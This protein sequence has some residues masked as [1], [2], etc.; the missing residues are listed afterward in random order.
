[1]MVVEINTNMEHWWNDY[2]RG[3]E[4]N[5]KKNLSRCQIYAIDAA[6]KGLG[7]NSDPI[8]ERPASKWSMT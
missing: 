8:R 6:R 4:K 1:M 5:S 3:R 7:L 2:E